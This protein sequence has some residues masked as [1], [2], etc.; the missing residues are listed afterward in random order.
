LSATGNNVYFSLEYTDQEGVIGGDKSNYKRYGARLNASKEINDYVS[1]GENLYIN[2]VDN[3]S[4]GINDAFGTVIADAFAYDPL[5]PI[6]S[7]TGQYGFAQSRWVQKEYINPLSRLFLANTSGKGDEILGNIYLEVSP[8]KQL[9]FRTDLGVNHSWYRF[10]NFTPDYNF[11]SAFVNVSNDVSQGFGSFESYQFE[12]YLN[13][14]NTFGNHNLDALI[15]T[16]YRTSSSEWSGGSSSSIPDAVKFNPNW[17]FI[18]SGEDSTDLAYGSA[19]VDYALISYFGRVIYDYRG[20]YLFSATLR[21][22]GSSNF[23]ENNRWGVFPSFSVG[24]I[25][26]DELFADLG[27]VSFLKLRASW[28]RNGNDRISPLSYASTVENVF[29]YP[30][31]QN[32]ALYTGATLATPPNPN[33][34]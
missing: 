2:R 4:L 33:I 27:P 16:S 21:R 5:T 31:G 22:D 17:Q 23:G 3:Q 11:H 14:S 1:I 15:G 28:G 29:T 10:R 24:W 9:T 32:P 12:N 25:I 19:S 13:Y 8:V 20:K 7:E 26:S 30:F 18:D 34:K 6:Y